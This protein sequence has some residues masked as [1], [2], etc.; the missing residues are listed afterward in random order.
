MRLLAMVSFQNFRQGEVDGFLLTS[1]QNIGQ[2]MAIQIW[3]DNSGIGKA[4]GWNLA[5]IVLI[6]LQE[7]KWY[8]NYFLRIK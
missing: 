7:R 3:H 6:D 8:L 1:S 4:A 2:P 5:K